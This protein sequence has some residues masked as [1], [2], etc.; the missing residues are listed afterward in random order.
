MALGVVA[1]AF[2]AHSL[3]TVLADNSLQSWKTAVLYLLLHGMAMLVLAIWD[4]YSENCFSYIGL[5]WKCF[6]GGIF[7]FSGSIFL[8]ATK[9]IHGLPVSWL[10]PITPIGGV[11]FIAGWLNLLRLRAVEKQH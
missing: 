4:E 10:G 1:G 6:L 7:L 2:G 3:K 8:L 11:F 9:S 5:S